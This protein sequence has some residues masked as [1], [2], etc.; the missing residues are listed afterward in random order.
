MPI[1]LPEGVSLSLADGNQV[2]VTGPKG[3]LE[4]RL[5]VDITVD[6]T[7]G[8]VRVSRPDDSRYHRALHGLTRQLLANMVEGVTNG[9]EKRLAIEGTGFRATLQGRVLDLQLGFSHPQRYPAPEGID[10][11]VPDATHVIVRGIDKELV[12]QVAADLRK[13]RPP[14]AYKGKGIRYEGEYVRRK[15]GKTAATVAGA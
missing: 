1:A 15:P 4:R 10:I 5:H 2:T 7:D 13:V 3:T 11:E 9:Y 14:D 6:C 12:G 8:V